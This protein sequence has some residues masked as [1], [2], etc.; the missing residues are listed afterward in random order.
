MSLKSVFSL[1]SSGSSSSILYTII[2]I[3]FS[4]LSFIFWLYNSA[5]KEISQLE[6]NIQIKEQNIIQLDSALTEQN[7][8]I[9][10]LEVFKTKVNTDSVDRITIKDNTCE[11]KLKGYLEL[12]KELGK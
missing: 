2:V 7:K 8:R 9:K 11:S 5:L 4:S 1:I 10:E 12:F 6:T 3:L